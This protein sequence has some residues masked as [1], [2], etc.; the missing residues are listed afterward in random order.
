M[1]SKFEP[2]SE[3][4]YSNLL[5][6]VGA[7]AGGLK[8]IVEIVDLLPTHF[9]GALMIATHRSSTAPNVLPSL[10]QNHTRLRVSDTI[11]GD[12]LSCTHIYIGRPD[13]V[14]T[15]E[16]GEVHIGLDPEHV[17]N[18]LRIDDLF[19]SIA[20]TA[21]KNAVGVIL[22]GMLWDGVDGLKAIKE[23]GGTCIVQTPEDAT[24]D[25]MPKNALKSVECDF[26]G[27]TIEI[28]SRLV[29]LGAGR[30]CQ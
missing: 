21:G 18:L 27:T 5:I 2:S 19:T 17:R 6:G 26:V 24:F 23:A 8:A 20:N 4:S 11:D 28:A 13:E 7:S 15:A 16:G 9:Q 12:K 3:T 10:L 1:N 22:S 14:L 30:N 25:S 29:E